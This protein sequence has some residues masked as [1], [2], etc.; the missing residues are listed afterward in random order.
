MVEAQTRTG[1]S[2]L[3]RLGDHVC[4]ISWCAGRLGLY[5]GI[6]W[7][8]E[9]AWRREWVSVAGGLYLFWQGWIRRSEQGPSCR[10]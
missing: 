8:I 6:P 3:R 4:I 5:F 1:R 10:V 7:A 2:L 9:R